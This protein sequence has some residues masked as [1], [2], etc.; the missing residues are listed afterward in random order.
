L[1]A[2]FFIFVPKNSKIFSLTS[3]TEGETSGCFHGTESW[4]PRQQNMN[5]KYEEAEEY[6]IREVNCW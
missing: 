2:L 3:K 5:R 4:K 1:L 6:G